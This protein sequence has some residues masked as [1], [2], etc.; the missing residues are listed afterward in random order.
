MTSSVVMMTYAGNKCTTFCKG[1]CG[2]TMM[3][4]IHPGMVLND[5]LP[6]VESVYT[7]V[8]S[9]FFFELYVQC[10]PLK[11]SVRANNTLGLPSYN[12]NLLMRA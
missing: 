4:S 11:G 8:N 6:T 7:Y 1:G 10:V 9:M 2:S 3:D 12:G 5:W